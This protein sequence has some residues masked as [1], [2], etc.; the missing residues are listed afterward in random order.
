MKT[1]T[2]RPD[3]CAHKSHTYHEQCSRGCACTTQMHPL[4][5]RYVHADVGHWCAEM[6]TP[7]EKL[8]NTHTLHRTQAA[9]GTQRGTGREAKVDTF[10]Q[11][12]WQMHKWLYVNRGNHPETQQLTRSHAHTFTWAFPS[13]DNQMYTQRM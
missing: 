6:G 8:L 11:P 2:G 7:G 4:A 9:T 10:V 3:T 5:Q 13:A 12:R 1:D